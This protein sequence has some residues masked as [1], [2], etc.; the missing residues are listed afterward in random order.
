MALEGNQSPPILL[1]ILN[2]SLFFSKLVGIIKDHNTGNRMVMHFKKK[3]ENL[4]RN[5]SR[6]WKISKYA[7]LPYPPPKK[8]IPGEGMGIFSV[9]FD[10]DF[11]PYPL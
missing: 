3:K 10:M 1:P 6:S 7:V 9:P 4:S 5:Y 2:L 8:T 11:L